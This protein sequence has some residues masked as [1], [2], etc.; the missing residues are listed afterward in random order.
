M[1]QIAAK[2]IAAKSGS[3][4]IPGL[5]LASWILSAIALANAKSGK[6]GIQLT[7]GSKYTETYLHKESYSI[8]ASDLIY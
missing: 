3:N 1:A 7:A 4:F 6:L 5:N 2:A 8:Y